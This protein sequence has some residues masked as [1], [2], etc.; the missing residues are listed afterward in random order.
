MTYIKKLTPVL[1][2]S[3]LFILFSCESTEQ[4]VAEQPLWSQL[5]TINQVY[6]SNKY[7]ARIGY[8]EKAGAAIADAE[9]EVGKYFENNI[10]SNTV[11]KD[12][13]VSK[14]GEDTSRYQELDKEIFISSNVKLFAMN[15]TKPWHDKEND[16]YVVCSYINRA[17]AFNV[18]APKLEKAR[19]EFYSFYTKA[20]NEKD[21]FRKIN[22]LK[23][24]VAPGNDYLDLLDF[25]QL[26]SP[27]LASAYRN[28][29]NA[30]ASIEE[31]IYSTR[32]D[33]TMKI[34]VKN[35]LDNRVFSTLSALLGSEKI[36]LS[37]NDYKYLMDANVDKNIVFHEIEDGEVIITAEPIVNIVLRN[38][39]N[40]DVVFSYTRDFDKI[41][42]YTE[43]FINKKVFSA[44]DK[45]LNSSF[46]EEFKSF[47]K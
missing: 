35:D 47:I 42:G 17:D 31:K 24:A 20:E 41:T 8:G 16:L 10:Q 37:K 9:A 11:S 30:I 36:I 26:I 38:R 28:D 19:R 6:P 34:D 43:S 21:P 27:E 22:R 3:L 29:I 2:L 1:A 33:A 23:E 44:I 32:V 18:F 45:E 13:F 46:I 40:G 15:H 25:A 14:T 12:H 4:V 7:I 39:M 5:E